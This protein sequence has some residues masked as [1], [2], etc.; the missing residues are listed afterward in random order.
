M[1]YE[2]KFNSILFSRHISE[3]KWVDKAKNGLNQNMQ[4]EKES[5][6]LIHD[7]IQARKIKWDKAEH[8]IISGCNSQ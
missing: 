2:T 8:L 7:K 6:T 4:G 5:D 3:T 1:A